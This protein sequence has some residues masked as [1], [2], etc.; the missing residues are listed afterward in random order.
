MNLLAFDF[1]GTLCDS[2]ALLS[3]VI[4]KIAADEGIKS[5]SDLDEEQLLGMSP[6]NLF[7]KSGLGIHRLPSLVQKVRRL[8]LAQS[9]SLRLIDEIETV[10]V[11]ISKDEHITCGVLTSNSIEIVLKVF[12]KHGVELDFVRSNMA[13]FSKS[14][15][16][17]SIQRGP[18]KA[19]KRHSYD[20]CCYVGDETRDIEAARKAGFQSI[21]VPWGY[22]SAEVLSQAGP[23]HCVESISELRDLIE[24]LTGRSSLAGNRGQSSSF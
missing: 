12:A 22:E 10:L 18:G 17:K 11:E 16:L 13:L 8:M 4:R 23:D 1:D 21:A 3:S 9:D 6:R 7:V 2:R 24:S 19:R 20:L 15:S 5:L 14:I